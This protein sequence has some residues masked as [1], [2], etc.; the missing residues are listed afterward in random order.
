M[1]REIPR[2]FQLSMKAK[3][4]R[5]VRQIRRATIAGSASGG[6]AVTGAEFETMTY[7][8]LMLKM[9]KLSD[10]QLDQPVQLFKDTGDHSKPVLLMPAYDLGTVE[11]MCHV[12]GEV[13]RQTRGPDFAHHPE[14]V[15]LLIDGAPFNHD[16]DTLHTME[17]GGLRGN[18]SG[19]LVPFG[20]REAVKEPPSWEV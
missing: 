1:K 2:T 12:D 19:K 13:A 7:R 9:S 15:I 14:Q 5:G 16:G 4:H 10:A 11:E 20:G 18:V 3:Y 8:E 6:Y 17:D